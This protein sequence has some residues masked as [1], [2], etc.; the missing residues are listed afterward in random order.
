MRKT[1]LLAITIVIFLLTGCGNDTTKST[2][3]NSKDVQILNSSMNSGAKQFSDDIVPD[4]LYQS[5]QQKFDGA[6]ISIRQKD[7]TFILV[8]LKE[9]DKSQVA[10]S[11]SI[12]RVNGYFILYEFREGKYVEVYS[13]SDPVYGMQVYGGGGGGKKLIAFTSGHGGTGLQENSFHVI[14]YTNNG[15]SEIWSGVAEKFMFGG[16]GPYYRTI[17]SINLTMDN[18]MLVYSITEELYNEIDKPD[19]VEQTVEIYQYDTEQEKFARIVK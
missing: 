10:A 1:V 11:V 4:W 14:G 15:Y 18:Q 8:N 7:I 16:Q 13:K 12:D 19:K 17:G 3:E 2:E 5:L 9:S 6:T